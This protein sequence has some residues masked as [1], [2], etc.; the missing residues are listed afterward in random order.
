MTDVL[1]IVRG[2]DESILVAEDV[3]NAAPLMIEGW[4]AEYLASSEQVHSI[5]RRYKVTPE[6]VNGNYPTDLSVTLADIQT[7]QTE[8]MAGPPASADERWLGVC[9]HSIEVAP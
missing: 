1:G 9:V 3:E 8:F 6:A 2:A 7:W 5:L 4:G